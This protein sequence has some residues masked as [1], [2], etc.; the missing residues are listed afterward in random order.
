MIDI[1]KDVSRTI[2]NHIYFQQKFVY[3]QKDLFSVLKCISIIEPE[4][5]YVQGMGYMVAI[6]LLY[7]DKVDAF[8]IMLKII[9]NKTYGMKPFY[10]P[11]MPGLKISFYI[12]LS[13]FKKFMPRLHEH[14]L[15]EM[16]PPAMYATKWFMTIFS[17]NIPIELTLR[18]WDVFFIEGQKIV[19]RIALAI[20]KI[21]EK[22]LLTADCEKVS[23]ILKNYLETNV[24][25]PG[26]KPENE[27]ENSIV[28]D[29]INQNILTN[30]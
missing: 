7:V 17:T 28:I 6:L 19:Y 15:L 10:M 25:F 22:A 12:F 26:K 2:P 18:I 27:R 9:N 5:G 29:K 24:N 3:G 30:E 13:L 23:I 11:Q 8:N 14:L 1:H 20:L 4:I 16:I 21:N